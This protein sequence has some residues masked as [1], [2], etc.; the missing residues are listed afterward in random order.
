MVH[1][2]ETAL[3]EVTRRTLAELR[4][5]KSALLLSYLQ[6]KVD[7]DK[8]PSPLCPFCKVE[9]HNAHHPFQCWQ[10]PGRLDKPCQSG[11]TAGNLATG[12]AG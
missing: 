5:N 3:P 10:Y 4:T 12:D 7:A 9:T 8:H 2:S 6:A 1:A 11:S